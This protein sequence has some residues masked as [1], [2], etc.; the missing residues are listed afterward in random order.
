MARTAPP[1]NLLLEVEPLTYRA[2]IRRMIE[3]GRAF[4]R[5]DADARTAL[6]ELHTSSDAY[7][8]L[9]ALM[10]VFGSRHGAWVVEALSDPSRSVRRRA[11][12]M[13]ALFCSDEQIGAA[14]EAIVEKRILRRTLVALVRAKKPAPVDAFLDKRMVNQPPEPVIV[15]MLPL[16]SET[17]VR[18]HMPTIV[19]GGSYTTWERLCSYHSKI[20]VS[21]FTQDLEKTPALDPRRRYRLQL[22]LSDLAKRDP[23]A[24][25]QLVGKLFD[26]GEDP[27]PHRETVRIL[28]RSRPCPTFD[29]LKKRHQSGRPTHPPGVFGLVNFDAVAPRL[30]P[31]RLEYLVQHASGTLRDGKFGIRW[32]LRLSDA[33][34][35]V[36][37]RSF[38]LHGRGSWGAFLFR[39]FKAES[40]EEIGIRQRAFER[41]SR[42]AQSSD[43]TIAIGILDWLPRDLREWEAHRHLERCPTITSKPDIRLPYAGLLP[44][45]Q[46][47][48]V[49]AP[50]L[51]HPEGEERAKAQAIL[52]SSVRHD[53]AALPDAISN[54]KARKFEQDPVRNVMFNA[55][56][57]LR[58]AFFKP[59]H[60]E[61]LGAII[62]D[63]LDAAD[64]SP[65]TSAHVEKLVVRLFR[66]DGFWAAG[67]MTKL[68]RVRGSISTWGLGDGLTNPEAARLGP[69][70]AHLIQT[71]ATQERAFAIVSLAQSLALRCRAVPQVIDGLERL[72]RELPFVGVAVASLGLIQKY[73][74]PRF[75]KIVPE[76]LNTDESYVLVPHVAKYISHS[77]QDLLT[78]KMLAAQPM[79]GRF[80]TGQ[81]S[82]IIDF[83]S[84]YAR[85]TAQQQ[86]LYAASL[87]ALLQ[88]ETRSVPNL[89][90]ALST[91]VRLAFADA[92]AI[93]P[94]ASDPRQPVREMA[95][96]GLPWLDARQGVPVLVEALGDD[97]ARWAIYALRKVFS[98]MR[99]PQVLQELRSVPMKKVTVAKEVVRLL[100]ELGGQD[101]YQELLRLN[102]PTA[103]RDVRIAVLRALWDHLENPETWEIFE[104]SVRDP[105][106]ILASKLA[107][108]PLGRL[109]PASEERV[110]ALLG[111]ILSRPEAEARIELLKR[112]AYIPLGDGQR[113]LWKRLLAH[114]GTDDAEEAGLAF[115]AVLQRMTGLEVDPVV[116]RLAEL[117]DRRRHLLIFL[118]RLTS[119]I[120]Q[121]APPTPKK[122]A[123]EFLAVLQTNPGLVPQFLNLGARLWDYD[124]FAKVFLDLSK[125]DWL[126]HEAMEAALTGLRNCVHPDLLEEKLRKHG[127]WRIRRLA[128]AALVQAASPQN[129]WTKERREKLLVYQQD[130]APGVLGPALFVFPP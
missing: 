86:R 81:T 13:V 60:L 98:E 56:G 54:I 85:W 11:T 94:F 76:L 28:L 100:G 39:Y 47:K 33:D 58:I 16:G 84:G 119:T 5:G 121:Y 27:N 38:L 46:A 126:Y 122:V 110:G 20:A 35:K 41:W 104:K 103:H 118:P 128:L 72:A 15:D 99:R 30:G 19:D 37:L 82:W 22:V 106:W 130:K 108:I 68:L 102:V 112:L 92:S 74:R 71:W 62:D 21:W 64:L 117:V 101:A 115:H 52:I 93:L 124:D 4:A 61:S 120:G 66:V 55:L 40:T 36:V 107:D 97:R 25:L 32:F 43:G 34:K 96:R 127:D 8:R 51:G 87:V 24:T 63:A 12:R 53:P 3:L 48:E 77:R 45:V 29:L 7:E 10:S 109:S 95:I 49:L 57:N 70:L 65:G 111:T 73:D 79:T 17:V 91:L 31:E 6:N 14:L 83:Q 42:A 90:F 18:R 113:S 2:R 78:P 26:Q 105:D 88:D 75:A 129:G 123:K 44:F 59:D 67:Y 23:D 9:L 1:P 80:A 69:A 116:R 89:R 114:M 50:W 125:K